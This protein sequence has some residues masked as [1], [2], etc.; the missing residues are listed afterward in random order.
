[1]IKLSN[2]KK[3]TRSNTLESSASDTT[4]SPNFSPAQ[5]SE[6]AGMVAK[7]LQPTIEATIKA[8]IND[9]LKQQNNSTNNTHW[10]QPPSFATDNNLFSKMASFAAENSETMQKKARTAVVER[11]PLVC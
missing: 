10:G 8:T 6:L 11:M 4:I 9:L 1:M 5:L 7:I 2:N 3:S